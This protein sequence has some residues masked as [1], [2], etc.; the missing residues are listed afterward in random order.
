MSASANNVSLLLS[1]ESSYAETPDQTAT[2]LRY[3]FTADSV[4]G[5]KEVARSETITPDRTAGDSLVVN[6]TVDGTTE[7]EFNILNFSALEQALLQ[8]PE[9]STTLSSE[10]GTYDSTA[11]TFTATS[12]TPFSIFLTGWQPRYLR[13][14]GSAGNAGVF[15]VVSITSTVITVAAG[16]FTVDETS[17]ATIS[18]RRTGNGNAAS[19]YLMEKQWGDINIKHHYTGMSIVGA[20]LQIAARQPIT[21]SL[22]WVGSKFYSGFGGTQSASAGDGSPT[23]PTAASI[24]TASNNVATLLRDGA[25]I[26]ACVKNLDISVSNNLRDEACVGQQ[27]SVA[28][29]VNGE[30]TCEGTMALLFE[31][32]DLVETF[33]NHTTFELAIP[34]SDPEGNFEV[35]IM[36][37]VTLDELDV[38]TEGRNTSVIQ[39]FQFS[40]TK[41]RATNSPFQLVIERFPV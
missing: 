32:S 3:P 35:W 31:N 16:S 41:G 14:A 36:P 39:T 40:T 28:R 10:A 29:P 12:G 37:R 26:G 30:F 7:H 25:S 8:A 27:N 24:L 33:D 34:M 2:F 15:R 20:G 5:V 21:F 1:A 19:S 38:P 23:E 11:Q 18:V 17:T 13:F 6:K 22:D 9:L 4:R